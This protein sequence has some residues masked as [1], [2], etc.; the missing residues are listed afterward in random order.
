MQSGFPL[1]PEAAST[2]AGQ[3]DA[4]SSTQVG[5]LT[6]IQLKSLTTTNVSELSNLV[7]FGLAAEAN[8]AA[9]PSD[10]I[11]D[12]CYL[13]GNDAGNYR[14]GVA[15]NGVALHPTQP[16]LYVSSTSGTV[17]RLKSPLI[18]CLRQLAAVANSSA[19]LSSSYASKP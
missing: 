7:E 1:F 10:I 15:L 8:V 17:T 6:A 13:H 19:F 18:E 16:L 2:M 9:L 5:A 3:V 11:L 14:R 12:R 4:L